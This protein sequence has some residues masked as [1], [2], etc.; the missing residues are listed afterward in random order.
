M[1]TNLHKLFI[2]LLL[3]VLHIPTDGYSQEL[4]PIKLQL[5]WHHQFQFAGYYAAKQKGFYKDAGLDVSLLEGD[6]KNPSVL[7]VLAG[8]ADFGVTGSDILNFHILNKP[9][10]VVS[11]IFQHSPYVFMT[12]AY[13]KINSPTDL[14][15]K[16][17]MVSND[18]GGRLLSALLLK[19]GIPMDSVQLIEHSWNSADLISGK[20]DAMSAYS[21][22]EPHLLRAMEHKVSLID[23]KDYGIDFYGDLIFTTQEMIHDHPKIVEDF[24][25][26]SL[27]GWQYAMNNP[28]EMTN[29]ILQL[30][31][32]KERGITKDQLLNEAK[33]MKK[34]IHPELV[35]I[36]H[37]NLGRWETMLN[38]YKQLGLAN[39]DAKVDGLLYV[40]ASEK[41]VIYYDYLLYAIGF[42]AFLFSIVLIGNWQLRKRV[43]KKTLDLQAEV[44]NRSK[45]EQRLELAIEAA[46]LSIWSSDMETHTL[47]YDKKW[48]QNQGI[49]PELF[50]DYDKLIESIHPDD[51]E[52]VMQVTKAIRQGTAIY[53][54]LTYR[55][56]T[57]HGDWK[58]LL[59]FSKISK[60]KNNDPGNVII[61]SLLDIDFIKRNEIEL[62]ET[63]KELRK[64]NNELEKFA[65]ITSHNLRAPVVN[66]LSLTEIRQEPAI[67]RE[68]EE[69]INEKIHQCVM[70]LNDTLND[71]IEIVANKSGDTI[72]SESLNLQKEMSNVLNSI[73]K[74]IKE[75]GAQL[76]IDFSECQEIYFPKRYLNSILINL[77]TN[78][79]KY[80]SD[81]RKLLITLK[82]KSDANYTRLY[83]SDNGIGI[84][85]EK[86]GN[87][88]FGLYQR[89]HTNI[90]GKGLGL[91]IIKSQIEAMDGK[92]EIESTPNQGTTF[93]IYFNN[94][95]VPKT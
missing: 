32:V 65:Y 77:L 30:P 61:G 63:T 89:F 88:I 35:E 68:L 18:Q 49:D 39:K 25:A 28:E 14:A 56:K 52:N 31:G 64:K 73:E 24:N 78:A 69:E 5:K 80:K 54:N 93:C 58:W 26:A 66:L 2:Y 79:I 45:A 67:T 85:L 70:Q 41:K 22:V 59:S 10:V 23:P 33:E 90:E 3:L 60:K 86:F 8:K 29:Y 15:G 38:I 95:E 74:Q 62:Q 94:K 7:N 36:G 44:L 51:K 1:N 43:S 71:L 17:I 34:L 57:I 46:G 12:L 13:R 42:V 91:Y 40:S 55:V 47:V 76:D 72:Q 53:N 4:K 50:F 9:V 20:V 75:S 81:D 84:N 6:K 87:K 27:K 82:T 37:M 11:V 48:F 19:E 92:I 16:K 83:F 21:T